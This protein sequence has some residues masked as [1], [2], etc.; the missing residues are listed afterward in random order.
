VIAER[1][2]TLIQGLYS[3]RERAR[4][5]MRIGFDAGRES[6]LDVDVPI[7]VLGASGSAR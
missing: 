2:A 7:R 5:N 3:G 1:Y 6:L 4:I